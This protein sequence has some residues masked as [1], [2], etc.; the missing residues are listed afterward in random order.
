MSQEVPGEGLKHGAQLDPLHFTFPHPWALHISRKAMRNLWDMIFMS[1]GPRRVVWLRWSNWPGKSKGSAGA[2]SSCRS[3]GLGQPLGQ[4][5]CSARAP[6]GLIQ[7]W[8]SLCLLPVLGLLSWPQWSCCLRIAWSSFPFT[9]LLMAWGSW[10]RAAGA[11]QLQREEK[12]FFSLLFSLLA[13]RVLNIPL[14]FFDSH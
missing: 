13:L 11:P 7:S 10:S 8:S 12:G 2:G 1:H 6:A 3:W 14:G 9:L 4:V 5:G